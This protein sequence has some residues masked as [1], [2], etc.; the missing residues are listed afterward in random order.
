MCQQKSTISNERYVDLLR[1]GTYP[2]LSWTI[3]SDDD[4]DGNNSKDEEDNRSWMCSLTLPVNHDDYS[5][6]EEGDDSVLNYTHLVLH[7]RPYTKSN[8]DDDDDGYE[9]YYDDDEM[10]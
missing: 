10:N 2:Y 9:D 4:D 7:I 8:D 3:R 1:V 5:K 6:E